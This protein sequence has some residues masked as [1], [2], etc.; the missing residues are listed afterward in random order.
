[1]NSLF[2]VPAIVFF[3]WPLFRNAVLT[4]SFFT[5]ISLLDALIKLRSC[6]VS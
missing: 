2:I 4:Y 6:F 1:M 3:V 5:I